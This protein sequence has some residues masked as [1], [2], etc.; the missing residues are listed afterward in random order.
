ML[1]GRGN[2]F[3][4]SERPLFARPLPVPHWEELDLGVRA[5]EAAGLPALWESGG[6]ERARREGGLIPRRRSWG[7]GLPRPSVAACGDSPVIIVS[8]LV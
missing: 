6:A 8:S 1:P 3:G 5:D 7:F 4:G 2:I